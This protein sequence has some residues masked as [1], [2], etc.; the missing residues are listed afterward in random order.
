MFELLIK[1]FLILWATIDPIGTLA[2][3]AAL[4]AHLSHQQ[5]KKIAL[6]A[7]LYAF[8]VLLSCIVL[9]QLILVGMGIKL[10]SL[11]VAGGIILFLFGLKMIYG[12]V[13]EEEKE[14]QKERGHDIA[15]FPIAIPSIAT[16][17]AIMAV[18]VLTD[19]HLYS[20]GQQAI[21][22]GVV[23]VILLITYVFMLMA[24]AILKIIGKNGAAILIKVMGMLLAALSV[25]LVMEALGVH[26]WV[27]N[28]S[29]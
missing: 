2:L 11:Q 3:F 25:E 9:G 7:T 6:R 20:V 22:T 12:N 27:E 29:H 23:I 4:T 26:Q 5:R 24:N 1:D 13:I 10:I 17:G 18:I 28:L 19:N 16:P 8:I 21:T 15:V 14:G